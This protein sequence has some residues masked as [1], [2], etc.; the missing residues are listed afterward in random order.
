MPRPGILSLLFFFK[1]V[2]TAFMLGVVLSKLLFLDE[3]LWGIF[4]LI[5][6]YRTKFT[7]ILLPAV[8]LAGLPLLLPTDWD[9]LLRESA[10]L[11]AFLPTEWSLLDISLM[12][13][14]F[15][16]WSISAWI[17]LILAC[18]FLSLFLEVTMFL[19][20]VYIYL[21]CFCNTF[22]CVLS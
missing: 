2:V 13:V 14:F 7:G 8:R 11:P 9:L 17:C 22:F 12:L 19:L 10:L 15:L 21:T 5:K 6:F 3:L 1:S 20:R 16:L 4:F 18:T